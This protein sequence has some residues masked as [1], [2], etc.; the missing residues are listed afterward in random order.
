MLSPE[1]EQQ[2]AA[3]ISQLYTRPYKNPLENRLP[4]YSFKWS[5]IVILGIVLPLPFLAVNIIYAIFV[6]LHYQSLSDMVFSC[7][8]FIPIILFAC[9]RLYTS[10][11][12]IIDQLSRS[13]INA[14][15]I[16]WLA[17]LFLV[18]SI[19]FIRYLTIDSSVHAVAYLLKEVII[20]TS[21]SVIASVL[22]LVTLTYVLEPKKDK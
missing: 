3:K 12:R 21:I 2:R 9:Y 11:R 10:P 13:I 4:V 16:F 5:Q 19:I 1:E 20:Y 6:G 18:P 14:R 17:C 7:I 22:V 8:I 15:S